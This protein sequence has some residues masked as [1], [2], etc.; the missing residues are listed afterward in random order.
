MGRDLSLAPCGLVVERV[1]TEAAGLLIVARPALTTAACPTCG[2]V[3]VRIHSTYQ[4]SLM[5]LPA[6]GQAVRIRVSAR[7]FRC[8]LATCGQRIFTER[9]AATAS[10][11]FARRTARLE[12]I[13]HHLGLA[14][15]GRPGQ[16]FA[17][18]LLLPVS[19]DTLLRVVRRRVAVQIEAPRVIGV[20]DWAFRRGHSY[21][22][23][24]VDLE[25][26][27]IIDLLPDREA[28]TVAAWLA[29]R[30]SVGI[31]ARDRGT[32]YSKPPPR[33]ALRRSR[34]PTVGT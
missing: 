28:A 7:R 10:L 3:S 33:G 17:R 15:G 27:R 9:L 4:R 22:T 13:V 20:D 24:V 12:G 31:I 5:D 32:G 19:K 18:R 2:S 1:E 11:P 30:P 23:I 25:R 6:H 16:S 14:L 8:V 34:S 26:R 29:A 21:G